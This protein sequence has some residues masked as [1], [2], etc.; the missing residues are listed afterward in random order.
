MRTLSCLIPMG[1]TISVLIGCSDDRLGGNTTQTENTL[2]RILVDSVLPSWNSPTNVATVATL[3]LD[4]SNFDF[5]QPDSLGSDLSVEKDSGQPIPFHVVFW[6][7]PGRQGRIQVR[8][9]TSLLRPKSYFK[10]RWIQ[11]TPPRGNL[12]A[13]WSALPDSQKL[14]IGSVLVD[15]F[16]GANLTSKLPDSTSWY[17]AANN[18]S[19][20][21]VGPTLVAA[22]RG[23][24]GKAIHLSYADAP[25]VTGRYALLGISI[26]SGGGTHSLRSLDSVVMYVRAS[27]M[28]TVAFDRLAPHSKG[29]AW[30]H[31]TGMDSTIW[32]RWRIRPEDFDTADGIGNNIGWNATR[33]SVTNFSFLL[34]DGKDLYVD[35]IRF[36]GVDRDDLK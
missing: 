27:G 4:S 32:T 5:S 31:R 28:V 29:K 17:K 35:D 19:I 26:V 9:D 36:Y 24:T 12:G 1:L 6:N 13:V 25:S 30:L 8:I 16:E 3:K 11:S 22:G 33:D 23:R 20:A 18:D 10:V 2:A 21:L 14:A 34:A 7:K 15:D